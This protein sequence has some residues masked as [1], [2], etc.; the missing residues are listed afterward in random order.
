MP[1]DESPIVKILDKWCDIK[2]SAFELT[3][4]T[5]SFEEYLQKVV[6]NPAIARNAVQRVHDMIFSFGVE[7]SKMVGCEDV[8]RYLLCDDPFT[9]THEDA[10]FGIE[11]YI[12]EAV[13]VIKG[14]AEGLDYEK[15]FLLLHGPTS[16]AKSTMGRLLRKG[17]QAYSR[18]DE[19]AMYTLDWI[20]VPRSEREK[21]AHITEESVVRCPLNDE[22]LLLLPPE[23]LQDFLGEINKKIDDPLK[24]IRMAGERCPVCHHNYTR[25]MEEACDGDWMKVLREHVT[26]RRMVIDEKAR[27]GIGTFEP[28]DEKNQDSTDLTGD[29]D[30]SVI[31]VY[32]KDSHPLAFDHSGELQNANRGIMEW[33][34]V[35]KLNPEFLFVLLNALQDKRIKPKN[36]PGT[37]LDV[38]HI[39]HTNNPEFIKMIGTDSMEAFRDRIIKVDYPNNVKLSEE[40]KIYEKKYGGEISKHVAP[41]VLYSAA[42]WAVLTRLDEPNNEKISVVD[43]LKLYDGKV[44]KKFGPEEV[45]LMRKEAKGEGLS[46]VS[47]R[48]IQNTLAG[49]C[50]KPQYQGNCITP[51]MLWEE[52]EHCLLRSDSKISNEKDRQRYKE[53]MSDAKDEY[54]EIVKGELMKAIA[55]DDIQIYHLFST[56]MDNVDA[57][58]QDRKM[59]DGEDRLVEPDEKLLR[60]I[61]DK[62][63]IDPK[64]AKEHRINLSSRISSA[65]RRKEEEF[66]VK[67]DETLYRALRTEIYEERTI[68][69]N[70]S[71]FTRDPLKDTEQ[72]MFDQVKNNLKDMGYCDE[73]AVYLM[74]HGS[75]LM[76][77]SGSG[78][79]E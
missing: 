79:D 50:S 42:F 9:P 13:A 5:M 59:E 6:D 25:L 70:Y 56:Y 4:E 28:A 21:M 39:G 17:F 16:S 14:A 60:S 40:I 72:K 18:I 20:K 62:M 30:Y 49:L 37:D 66:D 23:A 52:L 55:A 12:A 3:R 54:D 78:P 76:M 31:E 68:K 58:L 67:K 26:I 19:G 36:Q 63:G 15:R 73:C 22:P 48:L 10:I 35:L 65:Y 24:K 77:N 41:H 43:K 27:C 75:K 46:G 8:P 71:I 44:V 34:E 11:D 57:W 69:F 38:L 53:L 64:S 29:T 32:G 51:A 2:D 7:K 45:R 47:P 61:E 74:R 1:D 33:T